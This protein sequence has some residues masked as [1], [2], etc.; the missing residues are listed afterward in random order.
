MNRR[1]IVAGN[2]KMNMTQESGAALVNE[3]KDKLKNIQKTEVVF[4]SPFTSLASISELV[5]NTSFSIGGQ[6]LFWEEKGAYTGEISAEMLLSAGCKYVI[7]GHSERR[8]YFN[9]TDETVNKKIKRALQSNLIPIVCI[10]ESL[11]ERQTNQTKEVIKS[12]L[13]NGLQGLVKNE[14]ER[15]VLAYEPIWAIGT[16]QTAT[17]EQAIEVHEFIRNILRQWYDDQLAQRIRIQYGG[18]VNE[19]NAK[20]LLSSPDIDGA[21]VGG[22]SLKSE[23]FCEIIFAAEQSN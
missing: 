18:S 6:N 4:C 2:W 12:Q 20:N 10:G 16:G 14:M 13:Q 1:K 8:A 21:L 9:E 19:S 15:I 11:N 3:L 22:A 17:P 23:S 7:I 5:K